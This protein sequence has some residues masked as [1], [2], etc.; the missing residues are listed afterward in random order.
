MQSTTPKTFTL[1][2]KI[3]TAWCVLTHEIYCIFEYLLNRKLFI[4]ETCST[5]RCEHGQ[6]FLGNILHYLEDSVLYPGLF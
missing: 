3:L 5:N 4:Y 6:H 2:L 1:T